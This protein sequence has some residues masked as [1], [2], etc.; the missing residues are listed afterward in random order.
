MLLVRIQPVPLSSTVNSI[1]YLTEFTVLY[2]Y[3]VPHIPMPCVSL[4][5]VP[6]PFRLTGVSFST[7]ATPSF[8]AWD[9]LSHVYHSFHHSRRISVSENKRLKT[10]AF[11][12]STSGTEASLTCLFTVASSSSSN[13]SSSMLVLRP[14]IFLA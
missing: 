4:A 10:V 8:S 2:P 6:C 13:P 7:A 9:S 12:L 1:L 14:S 11:P 5:S 3:P